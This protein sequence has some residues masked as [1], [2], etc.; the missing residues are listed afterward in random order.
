MTVVVHCEKFCGFTRFLEHFIIFMMLNII[1]IMR[2]EYYLFP[3]PLLGKAT[4]LNSTF[5]HGFDDIVTWLLES[6]IME[7]EKTAFDRERQVKSVDATNTRT[8]EYRIVK[9][10]G[11]FAVL[12]ETVGEPIAAFSSQT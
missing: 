2:D 8:Q 3:K 11:F 6:T 7:H 5:S 4:G 9:G 1:K 10:C 12:L